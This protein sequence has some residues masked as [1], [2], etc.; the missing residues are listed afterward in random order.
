MVI[1]PDVMNGDSFWAGFD[2]VGRV[3]CMIIDNLSHL[4][5][6]NL[7]QCTAKQDIEN[8]W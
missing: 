3:P 1:F 7:Y 6:S 5:L 8:T 4:Y 2:R